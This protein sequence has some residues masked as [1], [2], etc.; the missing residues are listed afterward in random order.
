MVGA[1][2][3]QIQMAGFFFA[4]GLAGWTW[5]FDRRGVAWR[6][7]LGGSAV[8]FAPA[9]PWLW[10]TLT[11]DDLGDASRQVPNADFWR[12]WLVEYPLGFDLHTTMGSQWRSFLEFPTAG[13][14]PLRLVLVTFVVIAGVALVIAVRAAVTL[15]PRRREAVA[16]VR[17]SSTLLLA[18]AGF[19][20]FGLL[21]TFSFLHVYRHYLLTAFVLPF[22][23]V[24]LLGLARPGVLSRRLL[25]VLVAALALLSVQFLAF[26]H[27]NDGAAGGDYGVSYRAQPGR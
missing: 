20:A 1:W 4:A 25:A 21:L 24:A 6:W 12:E 10:R 26:I 13:G 8:G 22:L 15:W 19:V 23:T 14:T 27:V 5:L 2:L 9:L 17:G 18:T 16:A 3:G 7:W 11:G